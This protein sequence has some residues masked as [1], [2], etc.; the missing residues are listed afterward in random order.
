[1]KKYKDV[2]QHQYQLLPPNLGDLIDSQHLVRVV[3]E[4][5]T[6]LPPAMWDRVF[7]GGGAPSY[8]PQMMLKVIV[9]AY[10]SCIYSCRDM[11][12]A[13]RQ[14]I[15]FMWLTGM[16]QPSFNTINRF[17]SEYF[18][19]ILPDV[20]TELLDFL[21][22][23][24][25]IFFADYFV[26]GT[27]LQ[28]DAGRY[29]HVWRKNTVR[30]RA[31]LQKRVKKL[32][33]EID[34]LNAAEDERYG[35]AD[36]PERGGKSDVTSEEIRDR[37]K[38][39]EKKLADAP[40]RKVHRSLKSR[41]DKLQK[42]ADKLDHYE[43]QTDLLNGRN[44][45]SKT[46]TD[47]TF[48]RQKDGRLRA[49]YNVQVSSEKQ[50]VTHYTVSQNASDPASFPDHMTTLKERGKRY[51]PKRYMG[52]AAYGSEENYGLLADNYIEK[53]LKY[54][55]FHKDLTGKASKHPFHPDNF[56]YQAEEDIFICPAGNRMQ[57]VDTI[58][59]KTQTGYISHL[60]VYECDSCSGCGH[61]PECTRA[62]GNRRIHYNPR[63]HKYKQEAYENLT[64]EEGVKLRRRRGPEIETFFGDLKHNRGF[65]R[66][67]LR[68][69]K[70][71]EHELGLH[72]IAY[73]LRKVTSAKRG[74]TG[75]TAVAAVFFSIFPL[76]R[77]N[78]KNRSYQPLFA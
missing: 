67:M 12:K 60:R 77:P 75:I 37:A 17:R 20:F 19:E 45:Y 48:M 27:K 71:V 21:A 40:S 73:N 64:S 14:D 8:H 69:L 15:T 26:D 66:F 5:I 11:A 61:K 49:G 38:A 54:N 25:Y 31:A 62:K 70:K 32:F 41:A 65:T 44:S 22:H 10:A 36:L 46:D 35:D 34:A 57:Y 43:R 63:L 78:G 68:G 50:F 18:R 1:M 55:T 52:D 4:F 6:T 59:R 51:L 74:K 56:Q 24:N 13:I 29:T 3:D 16:Q 2:H 39:V 30:Y 42:E 47:A 33:A 28:A 9:Y 7:T 72:A 23:K 76:S 53:Y 58:K